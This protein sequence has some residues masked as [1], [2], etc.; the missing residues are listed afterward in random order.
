MTR[1]YKVRV[2][3]APTSTLPSTVSV[4]PSNAP[5]EGP[6]FPFPFSPSSSL[7][8]SIGQAGLTVDVCCS[9]ITSGALGHV[10]RERDGHWGRA[11]GDG[12]AAQ[13]DEYRYI[14]SLIRR[15]SH[16]ESGSVGVEE[17]GVGEKGVSV[18]PAKNL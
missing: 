8:F 10:R 2:C 4:S 12:G 13:H 3:P 1:A 17:K 7:F 9:D 16:C 6:C 15:R 18:N 5:C 11:A 14:L